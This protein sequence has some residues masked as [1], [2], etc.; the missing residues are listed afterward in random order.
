M[1]KI[2]VLREKRAKI[3]GDMRVLL[4]VAE[5][6]GRELSA[7][8]LAQYDGFTAD[9]K[10][11]DASI[12]RE[13]QLEQMEA[14]SAQAL[15]AVAAGI[16]NGQ[17]PPAGPIRAPG[18]PAAREFE[19]FGEFMHSVA[20]RPSDQRLANLHHE[21]D[22]RGEQRMDTGS[23]GG[24]AVPEQ[25][26]A[27]LMAVEGQESV[28]RPRATVIPAG[29]PPDA[30]ITMPALDQTGDV[31]DNV[32]GGIMVDKTAEGGDKPES[33]FTL[34]Q[35]TLE[36]QE[37]AGYLEATDKLLRNWAAASTIIESLFRRA[38]MAK[39]DH[40][41]LQGNGIGGPLGILNAGATYT[42]ART[43]A[44]T[45]VYDDIVAMLS[46]LLM[47]GG[48]PIWMASQSIMPKLLTMRNL[49]GDSPES[50][51]GE[52]IFQPSA[53]D[54]VPDTLLGRPIVWHERSPQ[55]GTAG[56]LALADLSYYLIKDGSGPFVAAS[57]HVKFRQNKTAFKIFW[58]V[59]GQPWLTAPFKQEGGYEV[60]PFV[61]LGDV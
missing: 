7:E 18:D 39:E 60:S 41:F 50:A 30:A 20:F 54:G 24:F 23:A 46:R 44:S 40:E 32:Y 9:V 58:N 12:E 3:V 52:L 51:G 36:P 26:R 59:D 28:I 6:E 22:T 37:F 45:V 53:R 4:T 29:T 43:T 47:R 56:D 14:S 2:Q 55:L 48:S 34:R 21:F 25:F 57:E 11:L 8:E 13:L 19:T 10:K 33:N 31:P 61:A 49:I 42:V 35:V 38:M 1:S 15:P 17:A 16:G 5:T 27:T